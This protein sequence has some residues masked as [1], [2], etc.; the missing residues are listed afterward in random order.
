MWV[1]RTGAGRMPDPGYRVHIVALLD[2]SS[3]NL[4][5][6]PDTKICVSIQTL[7]TGVSTDPSWLNL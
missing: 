6:D 4:D 3:R 7:K 2:S 1:L 5:L